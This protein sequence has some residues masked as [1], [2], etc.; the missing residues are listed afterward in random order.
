MGGYTRGRN[1]FPDDAD[2]QYAHDGDCQDGPK[3]DEFA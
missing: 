3:H 2:G 1:L